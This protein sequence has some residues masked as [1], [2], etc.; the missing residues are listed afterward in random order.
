VNGQEPF[1]I[2]GDFST[3]NET[4]FVHADWVIHK[5]AE[6]G[7]QVLLAPDCLGYAGSDEGWYEETLANGP[8]KLRNY[9]RYVG[10]RYKNCDNIIWLMGGNR[11]PEG[12][13]EKPRKRRTML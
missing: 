12:A 3:P 5:A 11:N 4:Y 1:T 9:G 2:P 10:H 6:K 8:A 7:I 13:I